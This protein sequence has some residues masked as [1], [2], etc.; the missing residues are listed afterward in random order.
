MR[1]TLWSVAL[2]LIFLLNIY[3]FTTLVHQSSPDQKLQVHNSWRSHPP[4][5]P[6]RPGFPAFFDN[7]ISFFFNRDFCF[8]SFQQELLS[9]ST[10][11]TSRAKQGLAETDFICRYPGQWSYIYLQSIREVGVAVKTILPKT[12]SL[13]VGLQWKFSSIVFWNIGCKKVILA[14]GIYW[15][16]AVFD[17]WKLCPWCRE[18]MDETYILKW[19][20]MIEMVIHQAPTFVNCL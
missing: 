15:W 12:K 9:P 18:A 6:A 2:I 10:S 19:L 14:V 13:K 20:W 5:L 1:L 3:S 16:G 7:P 11:C 17:G 8:T 4:H